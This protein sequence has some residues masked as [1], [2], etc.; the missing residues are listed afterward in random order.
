MFAMPIPGESLAQRP[1]KGAGT[2]KAPAEDE[3]RDKK[4]AGKKDGKK[5]A[6]AQQAGKKSEPQ[7]VDL[8]TDD[9][10]LIAATYFP[11]TLGKSAPAVIL[12]HGYKEKQRVFWPTDETEEGKN[13]AFTLQDRGYAVLTLDFRGHG[14]STAFVGGGA[15]RAGKI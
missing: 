13:L 1:T 15:G 4:D 6:A 9:G 14:R 10:V 2:K 7:A 11:S 3:A 5:E 8:E 12:L